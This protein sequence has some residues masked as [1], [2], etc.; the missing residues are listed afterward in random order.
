[1]NRMGKTDKMRKCLILYH[2]MKM[3]SRGFAPAKNSY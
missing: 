1:M 3:L 2:K